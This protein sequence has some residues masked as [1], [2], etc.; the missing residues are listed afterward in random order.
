MIAYFLLIVFFSL[1]LRLDHLQP[2]EVADNME[3]YG[4]FI[5]G[6][7]A[8]KPTQDYLAYVLSRITF[9]RAM[10]LG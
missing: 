5:P 6:I 3:K 7:P 4:G 2:P 1:L 9:P 10:Y 8:G